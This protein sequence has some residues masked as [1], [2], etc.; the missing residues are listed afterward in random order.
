M[1]KK[2]EID[3]IY[4]RLCWL[5]KGASGSNADPETVWDV[6]NLDDLARFIAVVDDCWHLQDADSPLLRSFNIA[7]W[8]DF[9]GVAKHIYEGGG[10]INKPMDKKKIA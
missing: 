6:L 9:E 1:T 4:D 8:Y 3:A 2:Q 5:L 7:K 10:R